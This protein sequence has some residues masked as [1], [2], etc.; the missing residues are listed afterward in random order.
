MQQ[1]LIINNRISAQLFE[2]TFSSQISEV[3]KS[4]KRFSPLIYP[5]RTKI[6]FPS[7]THLSSYSLSISLGQ[8]SLL[9][10]FSSSSSRPVNGTRLSGSGCQPCGADG[11][12][13]GHT[14]LLLS[15]LRSA[16][17]TPHYVASI[18]WTEN[19]IDRIKEW[20]G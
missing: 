3:T 12:T 13:L 20:I 19:R 16:N 8:L 11:F 17:R 1:L 5:Y 9:P 15:R 10:L 6:P 2:S 14:S 18:Q 4:I 7:Q